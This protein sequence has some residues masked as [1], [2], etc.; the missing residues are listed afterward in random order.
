MNTVTQALPAQMSPQAQFNLS[1]IDQANE[2]LIAHPG[3]PIV[4][5]PA[6]DARRE[7]NGYVGQHISHMMG[8]VDPALVYANN[9]LVWRVPIVLTTPRRGQL[10]VVGI[11]DV[12]AHS[13]DLLIPENFSQTIQNRAKRIFTAA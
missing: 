12:D 2:L 7:V 13:G 1:W 4:S 9:G 6:A 10:G 11:L 3:E 8:S 5:V